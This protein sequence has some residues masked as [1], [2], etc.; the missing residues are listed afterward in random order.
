MKLASLFSSWCGRAALA[1]TLFCILSFTSP[2]L[3]A[4]ADS[5]RIVGSVTDSTGAA[6]PNATITLVNPQTGLK[7][8]GTSNGQGELN[9]PAIP[10][11]TYDSTISA[12]GFQTE[13][14]QITVAV[15]QNL[16]L[17]FQLHPGQTNV[18]VNVTS[19]APLVDTTDATLGDDTRKADHRAPPERPQRAQPRPAD[20]RRDAGTVWRLQP[21]HG[22]SLRRER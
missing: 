4:Q 10:A 21:G 1:L 20:P 22:G 16:T 15:T 3:L 9:I 8:R 13:S 18:T 12:P 7:L 19:A 2:R 11:G 17:A 5:G 6:I 14:Q